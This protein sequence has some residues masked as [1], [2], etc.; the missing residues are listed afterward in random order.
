MD[1]NGTAE[2]GNFGEILE[3]L[4]PEWGFS[5]LRL[6]GFAERPGHCFF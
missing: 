3:C 1:I 2:F 5:K 4:C 6:P